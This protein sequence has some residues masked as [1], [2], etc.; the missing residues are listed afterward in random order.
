MVDGFDGLRHHIIVGR[1]N[2]N[3][4]VGNLRTAGTH[5]GKCFVA[6]GIEEGD[7]AAI[8]EFNIVGP[9][10]LGN[11]ARFAGNYI[12]FTDVVEQRCFTVVDMAHHRHDRRAREQVFG[13]VF[14]F[15]NGFLNFDRNKFDFVAKFIGH[16]R[17]G[18]GIKPLVDRNEHP[19]RHTGTNNL[20]WIYIHHGGQFAYGN[21]LGYLDNI[22][23]HLGTGT[24]F[25]HP[26]GKG[27]TLVATVLR[28]FGF[29]SFGRQTGK[30]LL[31]LFLNILFV[32]LL[33][34]RHLLFDNQCRFFLRFIFLLF[35]PFFKLLVAN[36]YFLFGI[37]LYTFAFL[38]VA[39]EFIVVL[40]C[41]SFLRCL[42]RQ[43][44]FAYYFRP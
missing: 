10:M 23:V 9:D 5:G 34:N 8:F 32:D 20:G 35:S 30:C 2:N 24:L 43:I 6:R 4:D 1:H 17:H 16:Y 3:G 38:F 13:A 44:D 19:Q 21:E 22:F 42:N 36:R 18:F 31:D 37:F 28:T 40:A 14:F 26:F 33:L 39:R 41:G 7:F 11:T 25:G 15:L 12:G 27:H 29:L